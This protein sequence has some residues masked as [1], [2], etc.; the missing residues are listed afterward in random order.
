MRKRRRKDVVLEDMGEDC[1]PRNIL[2]DLL[3]A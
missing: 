2:H 1:R 3:F